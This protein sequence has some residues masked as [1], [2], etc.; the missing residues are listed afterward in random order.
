MDF[1]KPVGRTAITS[2]PDKSSS[3]ASFGSSLRT[4]PPTW[5]LKFTKTSLLL[6]F[7][8]EAIFLV[9]WNVDIQTCEV[10]YIS[11]L[12]DSSYCLWT[13]R[14]FPLLVRREIRT[15]WLQFKSTVPFLPASP[16]VSSRL[17]LHGA[18]SLR[19]LSSNQKGTACSLTRN[20]HT[21]HSMWKYGSPAR[22]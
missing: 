4:K 11:N 8:T 15:R 16:P 9:I 22:T 21:L 1:P 6:S 20:E 17:F 3:N 19:T 12:S 14:N 18:V 2:F 5:S 7:T 10:N 13:N